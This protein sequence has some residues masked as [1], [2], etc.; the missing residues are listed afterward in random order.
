MLKSFKYIILGVG[1]GFVIA[2]FFV[3][4]RK[5]G[6]DEYSSTQYV[7]ADQPLESA[8]T[9][10]ENI[11]EL[12][13]KELQISDKRL[14]EVEINIPQGINGFET[15]L[16]LYEKKLIDSPQQFEKILIKNELDTRIRPG[17]YKL[18]VGMSVDEIINAITFQDI[19]KQQENPK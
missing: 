12:F 8:E 15:A 13:T 9:K 2:S 7:I 3:E 6:V 16:I 1:I 18:E 14:K 19:D 4:T 17:E 11:D 10:N 5:I